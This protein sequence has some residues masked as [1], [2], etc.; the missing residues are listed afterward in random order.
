MFSLPRLYAQNNLD[1]TITIYGKNFSPQVI[2]KLNGNIIPAT[3]VIHNILQPSRI[4]YVTI[5]LASLK[6]GTATLI[7]GTK[8]N[9]AS[10]NSSDNVNEITVAN[11]GQIGLAAKD[12]IVVKTVLSSFV[13]KTLEGNTVS[14]P[15]RLPDVKVGKNNLVRF[16]INYQNVDGSLNFAKYAADLTGNHELDTASF[17]ILDSTGITALTTKTLKGSGQLKFTVRFNGQSLGYK[18]FLLALSMSGKTVIAR[19]DYEI[20]G[21][22]VQEFKILAAYTDSSQNK[23]FTAYGSE[24]KY[25]MSSILFS[26]TPDIYIQLLLLQMNSI[27]ESL[28]RQG[29]MSKLANTRFVLATSPVKVSYIEQSPDPHLHSDIDKLEQSSSSPTD[30]IPEIYNLLQDTTILR[31][32]KCTIL[33]VNTSGTP[34]RAISSDIPNGKKIPGFIVVEIKYLQRLSIVGRDF[35]DSFFDITGNTLETLF[36]DQNLLKDIRETIN[37]D[38]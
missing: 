19:K 12:T 32:L 29:D 26:Y 9:G 30:G 35:I 13:L 24:K 36:F 21:F 38:L 6:T 17:E 23:S 33:L 1:T 31:N 27:C 20:N 34:Y 25:D 11:P 22:C 14:T 2:V 10:L 3:K 4:L 15:Q 5:P 37:N 8:Q 7:A 18:R 28:A 16:I